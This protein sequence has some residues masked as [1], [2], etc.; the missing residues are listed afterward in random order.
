MSTIREQIVAKVAA[1]LT[2]ANIGASVY[3]SRTEAFD[4]GSLPAVVIKPGAEPVTPISEHVTR[5]VLDIKIEVHVRGDVPDQLADPIILALHAALMADPT[6]GGLAA[7]LLESGQ[8]EPDFI[9]ADQTAAQFLLTYQ[10]IYLTH[11]NS[12][13]ALA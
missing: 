3:R 11:S 4:R 13:T 12:L 8:A 9:D 2:A 5:R 6:L 1:V 7:K 10:A